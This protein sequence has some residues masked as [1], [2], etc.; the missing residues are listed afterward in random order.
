MIY[1]LGIKKNYELYLHQFDMLK[2]DVGGTVWK[3][4]ED[5]KQYVEKFNLNEYSIYGVL[6]DW[7]KDAKIVQNESYRELNKQRLLVKL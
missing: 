4:F 1:T 3:T 2:K 6:A 5:V 7:N